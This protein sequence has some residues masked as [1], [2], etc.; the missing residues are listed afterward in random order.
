MSS[1][2][3]YLNALPAASYAWNLSKNSYLHMKCLR[4]AMAYVAGVFGL[5]KVT[6]A[7]AKSYLKTFDQPD[8]SG[9][10]ST[11]AGRS[12]YKQLTERD[13]SIVPEDQIVVK[14]VQRPTHSSVVP[15]QPATPSNNDQTPPPKTKKKVT[16]ALPDSTEPGTHAVNK[17]TPFQGDN[18]T[19]SSN[20]S[21]APITGSDPIRQMKAEDYS[22]SK[23]PVIQPKQQLNSA[24]I[25]QNIDRLLAGIDKEIDQIRIPGYLT[26]HDTL[27]NLLKKP[28]NQY[29]EQLGSYVNPTANK[30][31]EDLKQL[32]IMQRTMYAAVRS[33]NAAD[34]LEDLPLK[35]IRNPTATHCYFISRCQYQIHNQIYRFF[36]TS[37]GLLGEKALNI[38]AL[39]PIELDNEM[40]KDGRFNRL[41]SEAKALNRQLSNG[42]QV[43]G[44][45]MNKEDELKK[46]KEELSTQVIEKFR[47]KRTTEALKEVDIWY[48]FYNSHMSDKTTGPSQIPFNLGA[49]QSIDFPYSAF[50]I[51]RKLEFLPYDIAKNDL[52]KLKKPGQEIALCVNNTA[53][54]HWA[55]VKRKDGSF[56]EL[57]DSYVTLRQFNNVGDLVKHYSKE[58]IIKLACDSIKKDE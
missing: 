50:S 48:K 9:T 5:Y 51:P 54:H 58:R 55:L 11:K 13:I 42:E 2:N 12:L 30:L 23:A 18:E 33:P 6:V 34:K 41:S 37:Y 57:N 28:F 35:G 39:T 56:A 8:N 49:Y 21:S 45:C 25:R 43:T 26:D 15:T 53:H 36:I 20:Q 44:L 52:D 47:Q 29:R 3:L 40:R 46:Y 19:T 4:T 10:C 22:N 17:V 38:K 32:T 7:D 27:R 16:F 24:E 31:H 14:T 1:T